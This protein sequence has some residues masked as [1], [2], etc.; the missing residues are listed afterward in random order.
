MILILIGSNHCIATLNETNNTHDTNSNKNSNTAFDNEFLDDL[1]NSNVFG[2][3][4]SLI[5]VDLNGNDNGDGSES[6]PYKTIKKAVNSSK[7][8]DTIILNDGTYSGND[9]KNIIINHSLTLTGENFQDS[10]TSAIIDGEN[11]GQFLKSMNGA[12]LKIENITFQNAKTVNVLGGAIFTNEAIECSHCIFKN[13]HASSVS[14]GGGMHINGS[15]SLLRDCIFDNNTGSLGGAI[16]NDGVN[17]TIIKNCLFKNNVATDHGGAIDGVYGQFTLIEDCNF[18]NNKEQASV[19]TG[20]K[21]GGAI[22]CHE[23]NE[24]IN[25]LLTIRR[26]KFTDNSATKDGGGICAENVLNIED[27]AFNNN[28]AG[29]NGSAVYIFTSADVTPGAHKNNITCCNFTNNN[30]SAGTIYAIFNQETLLLTNSIFTNNNASGVNINGNNSM[31][32]NVS[33]INNLNGVKINGINNGLTNLSVLSNKNDGV[34][35]DGDNNS[36]NSSQI[37]KNINNGFIVNSGIN[38]MVNYNRIY[39]NGLGG[40]IS[41]SAQKSNATHNWWGFNNITNQ[42]KNQSLVD[43][44]DWYVIELSAPEISTIVN[45]SKN[46]DHFLKTAFLKYY[47]KLNNNTIYDTPS[48]LP[49]FEIYMI[50]KNETD[51]ETLKEVSNT[52]IRNPITYEVPINFDFSNIPSHTQNFF[53]KYVTVNVLTTL[54]GESSTGSNGK[55][56]SVEAFSDGEDVKLGITEPEHAQVNVEKLAT[57]STGTT[58]HIVN[59][60]LNNHVKFTLKATNTGSINGINVVVTD[61]ILSG[62]KFISSNDTRYNPETGQWT[63]GNLSSGDSVFLSIETQI[64]DTGSLI[65]VA[66]ISSDNSPPSPGDVVIVNVPDNSNTPK[67]NSLF[68]GVN[69]RSTSTPIILLILILIIG[70]FVYRRN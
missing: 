42:Y 22:N 51:N 53:I 44:S 33:L 49:Y 47:F 55:F 35:F 60:Q 26:C 17:D 40:N 50:F 45:V 41:L 56:Y 16:Y 21:G 19:S 3:V 11:D 6:S 10:T 34:I 38:N 54:L 46:Y 13:N 4:R 18:T 5:Y 59:D 37:L 31:L 27:C 52:D 8:N 48:L 68:D 66:N 58:S 7:E 12:V 30:D 67:S 29:K 64:M 15:S 2:A 1:K 61:N 69:L 24:N 20:I 62:L 23:Y 25:N 9:N 65:N 57:N 32:R 39:E 63:I 36:V 28:T 70:F 14:G 43:I